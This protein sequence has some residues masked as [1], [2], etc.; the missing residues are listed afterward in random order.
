MRMNLLIVLRYFEKDKHNELK[1]GY[2]TLG[3]LLWKFYGKVKNN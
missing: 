2:E 1:A 3:K